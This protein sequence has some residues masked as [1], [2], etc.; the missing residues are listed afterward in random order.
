MH[1]NGIGGIE[2]MAAVKDEI[3]FF[4]IILQNWHLLLAP[5]ALILV[6]FLF[7]QA[8]AW[9]IALSSMILLTMFAKNKRDPLI[10]LYYGITM[11][12]VTCILYF[13]AKELANW[14]GIQGFWLLAAGAVGM[15]YDLALGRK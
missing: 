13:Y 12:L 11:I 15:I 4:G 7:F 6:S 2:D 10:L 3:G 5:I 14:A 8:N 9:L 1:C